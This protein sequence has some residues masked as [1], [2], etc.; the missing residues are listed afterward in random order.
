MQRRD[1]F[2]AGFGAMIGGALSA[3]PALAMPA[4]K[5][6]SLSCIHLTALD[7]PPQKLAIMSHQGR[8]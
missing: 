3:A 5:E 2:K 1:L 7:L 6:W 8:L 4:R